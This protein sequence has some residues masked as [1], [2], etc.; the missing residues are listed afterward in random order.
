MVQL[1]PEDCEAGALAVEGVVE[2]A[3]D[4]V[5]VSDF[6]LPQPAAASGTSTRVEIR[7][8]RRTARKAS[9]AP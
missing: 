8:R 6:E 7:A 1:L 2:A 5:L 4:A 3:F 9:D